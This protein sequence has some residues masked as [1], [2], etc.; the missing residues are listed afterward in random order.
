MGN[1]SHS[2]ARRLLGPTASHLSDEAVDAIVAVGRDLADFIVDAYLTRADTQPTNAGSLDGSTDSSWSS[3]PPEI[4]E[5]LHDRAQTLVQV[6]FSW[7]TAAR[8][9]LND[10]LGRSCE[11]RTTAA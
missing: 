7:N 9:A 4:R 1:L 2:E 10:F 8:M 5:E 3:L 6:G 11:G